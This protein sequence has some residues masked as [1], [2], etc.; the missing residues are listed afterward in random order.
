M[1]ASTGAAP[2]TARYAT[3]QDMV[4]LLRGQQARKVDVVTPASSIRADA[5]NLILDQTVPELTSDGVTMTAGAYQPTAVFDEGVADKLGI[6][7]AYLRRMREAGLLSLY[8]G[9]LNQ[10]L[11]RDDR[12]F[13]VR[14]LLGDGGPGVARAFLSDRFSVIDHLDTLFAVLDGMR[15]SGFPVQVDSCDLTERR[16]YV[17]VRCEAVR[18]LAPL[19]LAGYR[20]PFTGASGADNPVVFAGF[21]LTNSETGCGACSITPRLIAQVCD[22]G[23]TITRDA[24]RAVHL[25]ERQDPGVTWNW[26]ADTNDK[27]LALLTAKVRD[28]VTAILDPRYVE[29]AIREMEQQA[30]HPV[31]DPIET[32]R[33]VSSKFRYSQ[34]QQDDI[35]SHFIQ[36]GAV[37]AGGVMHAVTSV[38]Q[39]QADGDAAHELE[40]T[41][42]KALSL[43]ASL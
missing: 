18:V 28:T 12:T 24:T 10:W 9:N 16:L 26:S 29:R 38:A 31:A 21:V 3:I 20:S 1:T 36:G 30:G 19:L 23:M 4:D 14:C 27:A 42:L 5:G 40:S 8:D 11:A 39:T 6:P 25:G 34:A 15:G 17:R 13:L 22:N 41:A 32:I 7:A 33:V 2:L 37:T 43:A 35:L